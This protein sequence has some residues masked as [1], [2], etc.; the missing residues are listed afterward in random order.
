EIVDVAVCVDEARNDR[1]PAGVDLSNATRRL[2][3]GAHG[4]DATVADEQSR[5]FERWPASAVDDAS[6]DPGLASIGWSRLVGRAGT[7]CGEKDEAKHGNDA[8]EFVWPFL[9]RHTGIIIRLLAMDTI[10]FKKSR[11]VHEN[12]VDRA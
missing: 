6:S 1:L 10:Q 9:T 8:R 11:T 4:L 7:G 2:D 12:C 3:F 5:M